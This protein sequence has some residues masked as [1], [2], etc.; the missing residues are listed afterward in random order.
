MTQTLPAL[1]DPAVPPPDP[2][3]SR[4]DVDTVGPDPT[5]GLRRVLGA[6]CLPMA[7]MLQL[8]T[9]TIYAVV[10]TS[11]GM[12]DLG[13]GAETLAFYRLFPTSF[14]VATALAML[15]SLLAI[16]GLLTALR[17]L[18]PY[19]PRLSLWAV[20][21]MIA[22]YVC[23]LGLVASPLPMTLA[24]QNT[25]GAAAALDVA[26]S[27]PLYM[28]P[29]MTFI[30]GNLLGTALLGVAAILS[31]GV[32]WY[33]GALVIGWPVGH[34][35]NIALGG[36][37]WF[38]VAGGGLEIIGLSVMAASALRTTNATWSARG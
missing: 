3:T 6:I 38:A 18:R 16:P 26:Q 19:R 17:V 7:F 9:N 13:G 27:G 8:A 11:S 14:V 30:V 15:G 22:G 35:I 2:S 4:S 25:P 20:V 33:A 24:V 37:E 23:Y 1:S 34:I 28:V 5:V 12:S 31:R 29:V 32:P 36:Q 21:L 10:S